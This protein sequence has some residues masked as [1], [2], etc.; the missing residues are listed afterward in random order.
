MAVPALKTS[1]V[2]MLAWTAGA[3]VL[4]HSI[5]S[6]RLNVICT[7]AARVPY[8]EAP[9]THPELR[10]AQG[11]GIFNQ[12]ARPGGLYTMF[13]CGVGITLSFP[14]RISAGSSGA[15]TLDWV[16]SYLHYQL[17]R[18]FVRCVSSAVRQWRCG[19]VQAEWQSGVRTP[20]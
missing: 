5:Q 13:H 8:S 17:E 1:Q 15:I 10:K 9:I 6:P 14:T 19:T 11:Q 2:R 3:V 20:G 18:K 12:T 7:T 16:G 4:R